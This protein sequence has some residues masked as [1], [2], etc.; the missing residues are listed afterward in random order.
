MVGFAPSVG[1]EES[2]FVR[3]Q[4]LAPDLFP[5]QVSL[6]FQQRVSPFFRTRTTTTDQ[7]TSLLA[8]SERHV[9]G[10]RYKVSPRAR[11]HRN[12][13]LEEPL[14]GELLLGQ[15]LCEGLD[16][17]LHEVVVFGLITCVGVVRRPHLLVGGVHS[18]AIL[19]EVEGQQKL[20]EIEGE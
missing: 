11:R 5:Q 8:G 6:F 12:H 16:I 1:P 18:V 3:V 2:Y 17:S 4:C 15:G 10:V 7:Q 13:I 14:L 20:L 19:V 9:L